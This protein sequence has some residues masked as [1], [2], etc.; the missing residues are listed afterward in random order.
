MSRGKHIKE[1]EW[2]TQ[3]SL[4]LLEQQ[5]VFYSICQLLTKNQWLLLRAIAKYNKIKQPSSLALIKESGFPGSASILKTLIY[6]VGKSFVYKNFDDGG[7]LYYAVY[8]HF[9]RRW[10]QNQLPAIH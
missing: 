7:T 5:D 6:L 8:D 4:L 10:C 3:A 2:K 9:L 1:N